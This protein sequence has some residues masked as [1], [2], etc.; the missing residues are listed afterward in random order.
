MPTLAKCS[1]VFA[2]TLLC[3]ASVPVEVKQRAC[4]EQLR[5]HS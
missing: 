5:P 4:V 2:D 3:D 1:E